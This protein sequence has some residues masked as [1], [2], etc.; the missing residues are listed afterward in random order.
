M[1]VKK[2]HGKIESL[3]AHV[4]P[5]RNLF[6]PL[7]PRPHQRQNARTFETWG[8]WCE[9]VADQPWISNFP[10]SAFTNRDS[11]PFV[12]ISRKIAL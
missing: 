10:R 12:L 9:S 8:V 11:F 4:A 6:P 3:F 1:G 7:A 2:V 5:S